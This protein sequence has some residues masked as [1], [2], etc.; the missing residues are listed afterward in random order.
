[1][2]IYFHYCHVII[3]SWIIKIMAGRANSAGGATQPL[4]DNKV[5]SLKID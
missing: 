2:C 5:M 4:Q 3:M 1:M